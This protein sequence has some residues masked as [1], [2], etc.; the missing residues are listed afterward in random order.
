MIA[1]DPNIPDHF[2]LVHLERAREL[3]DPAGS[4]H[5][6]YTLLLPLDPD[7]RIL[8]AEAH[9]HPGYCRVSRIGSAAEVVHGLARPGPSRDWRFDFGEAEEAGLRFAEERFRPGDHVI[10]LR[11]GQPHTFRVVSRQP[12]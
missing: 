9:R 11:G 4:L 6:R 7:G 2:Q 8:E 5:D 10:V 3:G 12:I 1:T